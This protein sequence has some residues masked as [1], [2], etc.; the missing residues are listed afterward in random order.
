MEALGALI[1]A[2]VGLEAA[3]ELLRNLWD[4]NVRAVWNGTRLLVV[5][6]AVA[7]SLLF[8][9]WNLMAVSGLDLGIEWVG[10]IVTG[11]AVARGVTWIHNLYRRTEN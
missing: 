8:S 7:T 10:K 6:I 4:E 5:V 2:A 9:N 1:V 11:L 3:M